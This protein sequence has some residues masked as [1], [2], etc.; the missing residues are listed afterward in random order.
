VPDPRYF[1][2]YKLWVADQTKRNPPKRPKDRKQGL[3]LLN[4]VVVDVMP[5]YPVDAAFEQ[6]LPP[7]LFP[8]FQSWRA[9]QASA[10]N[11]DW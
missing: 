4:S 9:Q 2:L 3:A 11:T 6:S 1:A 7:E 10:T 5:E 8:P